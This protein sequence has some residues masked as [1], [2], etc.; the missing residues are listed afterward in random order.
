MLWLESLGPGEW[1]RLDSL[2]SVEVCT[3][4]E[5]QY[6]H[7]MEYLELQYKVPETTLSCHTLFSCYTPSLFSCYV[8]FFF[9][10][11]SAVRPRQSI[12]CLEYLK[13]EV[14]R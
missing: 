6:T 2:V 5:S 13:Q 9:V 10:F 3:M 8:G 11:V 7:G 12:L 1:C 4:E 14:Q